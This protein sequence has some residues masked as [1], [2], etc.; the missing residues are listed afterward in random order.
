MVEAARDGK[1]PVTAE[2]KSTRT[3]GK[4]TGRSTT[5]GSLAVACLSNQ[6]STKE[7]VL[8][9]HSEQPKVG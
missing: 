3:F 4:V 6:I 1:R 7:P 9:V 2:A 8:A 5:P